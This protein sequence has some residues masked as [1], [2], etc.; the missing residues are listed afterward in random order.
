[1]IGT[2]ETPMATIALTTPG[3]KVEVSM[4]AESS[5]GK[6]NTK[7]QRL[8]DRVLDEPLRER[9]DEAEHD[10]EDEAD[11]DRDDADENRDARAGDD[12]RGDV[13]AEIVGPEPVRQR[14][15]RELVGDVDRG[16]RIGRPD[17][18]Q[19]RHADERR[20][21]R[22]AE[23]QTEAAPA[24]PRLML[25]R[26]PQPRIDRRAGDVDDEVERRSRSRRAASRH[27]RPPMCRGWRSTAA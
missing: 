18:R 17:E 9:G 19:R 14:W 11:A 3:P 4:I 21:E 5:A 27:S 16:R 1:M 22:A 23:P 20:R 12:L 2:L 8:H 24:K 10:A 13:A 6:A 15:R 26:G 25:A 7:S